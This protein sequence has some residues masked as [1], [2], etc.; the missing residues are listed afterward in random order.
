MAATVGSGVAI[1][2]SASKGS[3]VKV[4]VGTVAVEVIRLAAAN[5][6]SVASATTLVIVVGGVG[7]PPLPKSRK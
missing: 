7:V 3:I 2:V 6:V 1:V 5:G 4:A